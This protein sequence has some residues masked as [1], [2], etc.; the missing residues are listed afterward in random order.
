MTSDVSKIDQKRV[1]RTPRSRFQANWTT[2]PRLVR[3]P[4]TAEEGRE[5]DQQA[6]LMVDGREVGIQRVE[7]LRALCASMLGS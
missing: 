3:L 1:R 4:S 6:R 7:T 2:R 5:I